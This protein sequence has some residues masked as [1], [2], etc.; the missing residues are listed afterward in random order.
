MIVLYI[1]LGILGFLLFVLCLLGTLKLSVRAAYCDGALL[2][3][4]IGPFKLTLAGGEKR[5]GPQEERQAKHVAKQKPK[6]KKKKKEKKPKKPAEGVEKPPLTAVIASFRD[7]LVGLV[8]SFKRHLK[9][10]ELRLRVLV[11]SGDAA[12]TALEYATV[13]ALVEPVYLLAT[14]ARR[15]RKDRVKV[16][17]ECDFLAEKPEIDAEFCLSIRVWRLCWIGLRSAKPLIHAI[18]LLRAYTSAP[19]REKDSET[20]EKQQNSS[21]DTDG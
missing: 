9:I 16:G 3:I 21:S 14:Q 17:I 7:L 1:L 8:R 4:G 5:K 18:S 6:K 11:A 2:V 20:D 12:A 15:V 13:C 19:K 10:E